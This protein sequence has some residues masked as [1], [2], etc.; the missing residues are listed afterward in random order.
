MAERAD[1][2]QLGEFVSHEICKHHP[3]VVNKW[4][5]QERSDHNYR[6]WLQA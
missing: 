5:T 2:F 3:Q 4:M 6:E 1:D